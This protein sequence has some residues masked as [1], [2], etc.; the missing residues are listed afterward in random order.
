M[1]EFNYMI[2]KLP[3]NS[4]N[5]TIYPKKKDG[6]MIANVKSISSYVT[7]QLSLTELC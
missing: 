2:S 7:S 4:E 5:K 1:R 3:V 6:L